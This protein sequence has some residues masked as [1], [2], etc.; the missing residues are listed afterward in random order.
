[1]GLKAFREFIRQLD[2]TSASATSAGRP[3]SSTPKSSSAD[4]PYGS[5]PVVPCR[6]LLERRLEAAATLADPFR[7][8]LEADGIF[9][10]KVL[11]RVAVR[12]WELPPLLVEE[13][14]RMLGLL[15]ARTCASAH[16]HAHGGRSKNNRQG[17][18]AQ[19]TARSKEC[20]F[21]TDNTYGDGEKTRCRHKKGDGAHKRQHLV[22]F[23]PRFQRSP[24]DPFGR[25]PRLDLIQPS[26]NP[27]L[28]MA[29]ERGN[30]IQDVEDDLPPGLW[31]R[32]V[33]SEGPT[34]NSEADDNEVE[35]TVTRGA[36]ESATGILH[37]VEVER[38]AGKLPQELVGERKL[39]HEPLQRPQQLP[40]QV[41]MNKK[42]IGGKN[43]VIIPT[44]GKTPGW[45]SRV[46]CRE[47]PCCTAAFASASTLRTHER[48][49]ATA[50]AYHRFRRAAQLLRDPP[51]ARS[52]GAGAPIEK[53]RLRT[54]LPLSVRRE[55][56]S[57]QHNVRRRQ[58]LL[59]GP[60]LSGTVATWA[61]VVSPGR[62]IGKTV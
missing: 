19:P 12:A 33:A 22:D 2:E 44:S 51:P 55:L 43:R 42:S 16:Y 31:D 24:I 17:T 45:S 21:S 36:A 40:Q 49:H 6:T 54:T 3:L 34:V 58:S 10:V 7:L 28:P 50:P 39:Q 29:N 53:F 57:L 52:E 59:A 26:L 48:S 41:V 13:L 25:P 20:G 23:D 62:T 18:V 4:R 60:G 46:V 5:A 30:Q 15:I 14:E 38:V 61:G 37:P 11:A 47:R 27:R 9:N 8:R 56:Q 32:Q 1:M 35:S